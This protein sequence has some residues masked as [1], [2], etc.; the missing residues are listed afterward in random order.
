MSALRRALAGLGVL[1]LVL[2][3]LTGALIVGS[4]HSSPR[5]LLLGLILGAGWSFAF[6]G[7]YAWYQ[8]PANKTGALMTAIGFTWF[9]QGL[10]ASNNSVVFAIG[11]LGATVPFAILL[12]LLASF[13]SGRIE[14]RLALAA[15][16]LGYIATVPMQ[17][18]WAPLVD[19]TKQ[20]DCEGCPENPILISGHEGLADAISALQVIAGVTAIAVVIGVVFSRWRRSSPAQR[21]V[22]TPVVFTGGIAFAI[23]L[24]Q[25]VLGELGVSETVK[26]ASYIA[27]ITIFACLPLAFLAGLLRSRIGRA[28]EVSSALSAEN[29]QLN[30]ELEAKVEELRASRH[31]IVEAGYAERRRVERNLHDGA[32]QRLM[33]LTMNLRLAREKLDSDP[34]LAA[35]LLDEAMEELGAATAELRELA[36]GIHPVLLSER[37]LRAALGG[38]A[39]R[40]PVPVQILE[41]P[42]ER[43]P[44]AVEMAAYFVVAEALTN[45]ARY[46]DA[47][48]ATVRVARNNGVV[49]VE[50]SDDGGGG[51][52]PAAGTGLRGLEDRVAAL[53]GSFEVDSR[54]GAG[55][56]VAA[57]IPCE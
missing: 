2:G 18:L 33:A 1:A 10:T 42:A 34:A 26:D 8:R 53:D 31:R 45:V 6:T 25:L 56:T 30:A 23:L 9:F 14:S 39:D 51:A 44:E 50:V 47:A 16:W 37:G 35:E 15:V 24:V 27:S 13:P 4:D 36:R 49:E 21:R 40:S 22:L 48:E 43:L 17:L 32:Q 41:T 29:A 28:E 57:R 19:P 52:D 7:L 3:V 20:G 46:A 38:L 55:T 5:G 54:A 11:M 12:Q